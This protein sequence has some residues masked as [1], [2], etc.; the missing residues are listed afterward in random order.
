LTAGLG[1]GVAGA[2]LAS[3]FAKRQ[4]KKVAPTTIARGASGS[5][6]DLSKRVSESLAEGRRAM[7]Q[8]EREVRA[9][10]DAPSGDRRS[11]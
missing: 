9:S 3:R 1:A 7:E 8:R 10:L 11:A 2:V 5:L 4:M 6:L